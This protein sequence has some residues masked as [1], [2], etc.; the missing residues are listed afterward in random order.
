MPTPFQYLKQ[1]ID[2]IK[3]NCDPKY[4]P[5]YKRAFSAVLDKMDKYFSQNGLYEIVNYQPIVE[6]MIKNDSKFSFMIDDDIAERHW[7]GVHKRWTQ[8][9]REIGMSPEYM[10]RGT[11]TEGVLCHEFVHHL[12]LGPE[13]LTYTK[14]GDRYE[15][16]LPVSTGSVR[17]GGMKR[18]LD[19]KSVEGLDAG[20]AL[21]GGFICEA[22]TELVKAATK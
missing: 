16:Q 21:D 9:V 13:I 8:G 19:K 11:T 3:F 17:L 15:T 18:N 22:F 6:S 4:I 12:T 1:N 14:D 5:E 2:K 7:A 10:G 20:M